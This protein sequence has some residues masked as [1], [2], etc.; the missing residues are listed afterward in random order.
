MDTGSHLM[1]GI[2]LAGLAYIDPAVSHN[3]A[4]AQAVLIGTIIGANAPD[5]DMV[6]RIKGY[7]S[8]LRYH[9]GIT[10]SIPA[11]FIWPLVIMFLL[12]MTFRLTTFWMNLYMW[13]FIAVI[14]HVFL[15]TLN[16][17]GVQSMRPFTK[18]GF[19][20][21]S[22]RFSTL[23]Y[24]SFIRQALLFGWVLLTNPQGFSCMY[25]V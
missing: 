9:R 3:P 22:W 4:L 21:I 12:A 2:S 15:D 17:Y 14:L 1:F 11:L 20:L 13:T 10:H 23:F 16:S 7:A 19:N 24:L 18:N 6:T 25:I 8:Y 5:F